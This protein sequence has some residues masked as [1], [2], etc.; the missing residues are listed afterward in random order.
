MNKEV[1]S[2]SIE[3]LTDIAERLRAYD[4]KIG[5]S[6]V[7]DSATALSYIDPTDRRQV[8]LALMATMI[9]DN[10]KLELLDSL[11]AGGRSEQKNV[12]TVLD[13]DHTSLKGEAEWALAATYSPDD[14][15]ASPLF[16]AGEEKVK[17]IR[18]SVNLL[19]RKY[20]KRPGRRSRSSRLG[21][22]DFK[23]MMRRNVSRGWLYK[24][25]RSKK[26]RTKGDA[27]MVCDVS[28]SMEEN[29]KDIF[30][31][32]WL[33]SSLGHNQ[34][35]IFSTEL[36][37]VTHVLKSREMTSAS[38]ELER[39]A[40]GLG[41]G[42]RIGYALNCLA[43]RYEDI[44]KDYSLLLVI[45]DGC[46]QGNPNQIDSSMKRLSEFVGNIIWFNPLADQSSYK[47]ETAAMV[48]SLPYLH[49]LLPLKILMNPSQLKKEL[50]Q[51]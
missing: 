30:P 22:I 32:L 9:K 2:F 44:L 47:P 14:M 5:T 16:K 49:K 19:L 46:D 7:I 13:Y 23:R 45:S 21:S 24:V 12:Y 11:M 50:V 33:F 1:S 34:A 3:W 43:T 39:Y 10:T 37:C 40:G 41:R 15:S 20:G 25:I 48:A 8:Y 6:E 31:V 35:F 38:K 51:G 27:V 18:L 42:T 36:L 26:K 29:M 28:G 17:N 4:I